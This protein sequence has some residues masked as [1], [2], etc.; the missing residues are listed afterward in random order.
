MNWPRIRLVGGWQSVVIAAVASALIALLFV[1]QPE[2]TLWWTI[3]GGEIWLNQP[4][5]AFAVAF[6]QHH[7]WECG[8]VIPYRWVLAVALAVIAGALIARTRR[9]SN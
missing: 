4:C 1:H 6:D 2:G 5:D 8:A 7:L 9:N 3:W